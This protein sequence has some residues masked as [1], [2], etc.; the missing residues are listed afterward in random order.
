MSWRWRALRRVLRLSGVRADDTAATFIVARKTV[1]GI[2]YSDCGPKV[3]GFS[4][5]PF[6]SSRLSSCRLYVVA[7]VAQSRSRV[8]RSSLKN[9][10]LRFQNSH[11]LIQSVRVLPPRR[12]FIKPSRHTKCN[13]SAITRHRHP[14]TSTPLS[15]CRVHCT[16]TWLSARSHLINIEHPAAM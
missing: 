4:L 2:V 15:R 1:D 3:K 5:V 9:T 11:R 16:P 6:T 10:V 13:F 12:E 14:S 7:Q 8:T